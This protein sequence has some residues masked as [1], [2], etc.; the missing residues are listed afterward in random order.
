MI[1]ETYPL[2][3]LLE[4][5]PDYI[6]PAALAELLTRFE[7]QKQRYSHNVKVNDLERRIRYAKG[8]PWPADTEQLARLEAKLA[9]LKESDQVANGAK[10]LPPPP[11]DEEEARTQERDSPEYRQAMGIEDDL[12]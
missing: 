1:T 4:Q 9:K 3:W 7:A 8:R 11:F 10:T 2:K 6:P 12:L 5:L